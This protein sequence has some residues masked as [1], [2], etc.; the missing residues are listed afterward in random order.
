LI[1][2]TYL[3]TV[4]DLDLHLDLDVLVVDLSLSL[5]WSGAIGLEFLRLVEL[6][7]DDFFALA[8]LKH[9]NYEIA[10]TLLGLPASAALLLGTRVLAINVLLLGDALARG[11]LGSGRL[12]VLTDGGSRLF[13]ATSSL[14]GS[15]GG[16]AAVGWGHELALDLSPGVAGGA[17]V[18]HAREGGQL[19]IVDLADISWQCR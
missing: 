10:L 1:L 4:R 17:G 11:L 6:L 9:S 5:G 7:L 2:V 12:A 15:G 18:G 13:A 19:L 8:L 14:L 16:S 3:E